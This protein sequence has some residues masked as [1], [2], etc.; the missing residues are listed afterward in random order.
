MINIRTTTQSGIDKVDFTQLGF[1]NY[2]SD[3]MV[4]ADY[5]NGKWGA[6]EIIP[7]GDL[8]MSP[9]MLALH[10]GQAV[11]EGM[12]AF[13]M[14][15]GRTCLFRPQKHHQRLN[16]SLARMCMPAIPEE[17]FIESLI[18]LLETDKNWI[19]NGEGDSLY[20]RPVVFATE[21]RLGVK[22]SDEY[23]FVIMTSPVGP[24]FTKP[25]KVKVEEQYVRAAEGG[26]GFAKCAGN[27]GGAFYPTQLARE[28]GYDQVLWTDAKEHKY[29]D[30]SGAMN[31]MFVLNNVLV[32][33]KL[34]TSLLDGITRDSILHL[35]D[36]RG[37]SKEER[38]VSVAEIEA[39]L[40]N[41][42]LTEAF[43]VGTAA[44]VS[45]I[46]TIHIHGTDYPIP[47]PTENSFQLSVKKQL[48][49]IRKGIIADR[50]NW[51]HIL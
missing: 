3:H 36:E 30:E 17:L 34:S 15:D 8:L 48:Q 33:P 19:P 35:A 39:G 46:Q 14:E 25:V 32:T 26:T 38:K 37:V 27:Y 31:V 16:R 13:K 23:K 40:K 47:L 42:T 29:I 6:A 51:L 2:I 24:Y 22:I 18:A 5:K 50:Y 20:I 49:Q 44:V 10:Y 1:G 9:A 4:V 41:K 7:Y 12:K 21:S 45:T 11:F 28:Q 43:G